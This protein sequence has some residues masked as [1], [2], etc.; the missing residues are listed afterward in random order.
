MQYTEVMNFRGPRGFLS[1]VAEAAARE[2]LSQSEFARR[3]LMER[4]E[5]AG[6]TPPPAQ[7]SRKRRA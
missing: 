4:M 2:K 5:R 3:A 6:V 1:A 7:K